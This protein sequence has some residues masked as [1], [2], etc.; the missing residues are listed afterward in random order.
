MVLTGP[1][2]AQAI[3]HG[4]IVCEPQFWK[5][6]GP[7][8]LDLHLGSELRT[9]LRDGPIDSRNPPPTMAVMEREQGG[10]ILEPGVLYLGGTAERVGTASD[11][12]LVPYLDGRSSLARLGVW[13]HLA[14]GRGD[15]GF[16]GHWTLELVA[17]HPVILYPGMRAF[18][19]TFI[20]AVGASSSYAGDYAGQAGPIASRGIR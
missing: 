8:S 4:R 6:I 5:T 15:V 9:Y 19:M 11:S 2:I 16:V 20:G 14:A 1:A 18:Q 17:T 10:W 12:G 3:R 13:A 7:N